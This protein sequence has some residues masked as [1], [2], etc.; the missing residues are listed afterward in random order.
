M[1]VSARQVALNVGL[2]AL[3]VLVTGAIFGAL[4]YPVAVGSSLWMSIA[5]TLVLSVAASFAV[6]TWRRRGG[7]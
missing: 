2:V 3:V 4:G 6:Q 1:P 7:E 5:L